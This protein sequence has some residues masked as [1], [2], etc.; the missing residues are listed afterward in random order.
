MVHR[1]HFLLSM[2]KVVMAVDTKHKRNTFIDS[3]VSAINVYPLTFIAQQTRS[4][5]YS[6]RAKIL[7][8]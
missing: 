1:L 2:L 3:K 8:A 4:L 7:R 6:L 5:L